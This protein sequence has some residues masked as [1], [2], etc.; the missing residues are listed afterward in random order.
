MIRGG[1]IVWGGWEPGETG[2]RSRR[3]RLGL[4]DDLLQP[5][6]TQGLR[7]PFI[8]RGRHHDDEWRNGSTAAS[9]SS[10]GPPRVRRRS[11]GLTVEGSSARSGVRNAPLM[12]REL[13]ARGRRPAAGIEFSLHQWG[14]PYA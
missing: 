14:G 2:R 12:E 5:P 4:R 8:D 7:H 1:L 11:V 3:R 6:I 10:P 9:E 13:D